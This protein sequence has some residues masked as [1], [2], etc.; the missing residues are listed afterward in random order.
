MG[1]F[2]GNRFFTSF[3]HAAAF[4]VNNVH[5]SRWHYCAAMDPLE[6]SSFGQIR[7]ITPDG[8]N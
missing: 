5:K 8:L 4:G 3:I 7:K 6:S 1:T 2:F